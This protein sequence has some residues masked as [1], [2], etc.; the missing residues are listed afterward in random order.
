MFSN[1]LLLLQL[2]IINS[3]STNPVFMIVGP[4]IEQEYNFALMTKGLFHS[5]E[6]G[7]GNY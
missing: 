2:F 7:K 5:Q 3:I 1:L 6:C 4:E